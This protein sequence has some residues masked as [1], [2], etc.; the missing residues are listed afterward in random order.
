[1]FCY[2]VDENPFFSYSPSQWPSD[3]TIR[4]FL[5]AY[6][7]CQKVDQNLIDSKIIEIKQ[8]SFV[9]HV[10]WALWALSKDQSDIKFD[11]T[12]YAQARL[13]AMRK[14]LIQLDYQKI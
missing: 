1:M 14:M 3:K 4:T 6:F 11:Y 9:S 12:A 2:E 7:H 8:F 10:F 13:D 5:S